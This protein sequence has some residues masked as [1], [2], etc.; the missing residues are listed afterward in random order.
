MKR[1]VFVQVQPWKG[2]AVGS[3]VVT[4][5]D[6]TERK[7]TEETLKEYSERLEE[8]VEERTAELKTANEQL[9]LEIADRKQVEEALQESEAKFRTIFQTV[10]DMITYVDTHGRILDVNDR[11]ED[12]LGYKRDEV[13]GRN[14][15]RLGVLGL[16][17]L[18]NMVRL[19]RE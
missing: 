4:V 1:H 7:L 17:D 2:E 6:I 8:M 16:R 11:V 5:Q 18:P 3:T 15:A 19:F 10:T 14:F 12:L 9:R 13:V